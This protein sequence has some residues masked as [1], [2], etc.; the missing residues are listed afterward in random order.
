[1][2][3]RLP[4]M[5]SRLFQALT[6]GQAK[7]LKALAP[8]ALFAGALASAAV[9]SGSTARADDNAA[10]NVEWLQKRLDER[11]AAIRD[12]LRRVSE[13]EEQERKAK[14][15]PK[16]VAKTQLPPKAQPKADPPAQPPAQS[17][18]P[19][20]P[21]K[22]DVDEAAAE[23]ALERALVQSGVLLLPFGTIEL[24][25][26]LAYVRRESASPGQLAFTSNGG[27]A[28]ADNQLRQDQIEA[29]LLARA[30]LPWSMQIE[31]GVPYDYK[32]VS[33][34]TLIGSTG[35]S[36]HSVNGFG[37]GDPAIMLSKQFTHEGEW[38]PNLIANLGWDTD[39]GETV[40]GIPL[41]TG[42]SELKASVT[43]SKRQDPLVFTAGLG[44][45]TAFEKH[46]I[47]PGDQYTVTGGMFLAVSPETSLLFSPMVTFAG[48]TT[49][50][51][52][53]IPGSD[54]VAAALEL[55]LVTVLAPRLLL[56]LR[57]D[58]GL[59]HDAP[60]FGVKASFPLQWTFAK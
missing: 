25:P 42:F 29:A 16:K 38:L 47:Q 50:N 46:G 28:V 1:M 49:F 6:P 22:F 24:V 35:V 15:A 18:A 37:F 44:Y 60:K 20:K 58:I 23:H 55:G 54:Q 53:A 30:G 13:L 10:P 56:D 33:N 3:P 43:A 52:V 4:R 11:D 51:G 8:V 34:V 5:L 41:G 14:A 21:G 57:F 2:R 19:A 48:E 12:L 39:F 59:T 17:S 40:K 31:V 26:S 9:P 27:V 36:Q 32:S 7:L 45:T